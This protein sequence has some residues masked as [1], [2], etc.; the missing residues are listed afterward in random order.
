MH[1]SRVIAANLSQKE[2]ELQK[3]HTLVETAAL[4]QVCV[5]AC[6]F[7]CVFMC[8]SLLIVFGNR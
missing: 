8:V 6:V 4:L 3:T 5:C 7:V 1:N 2:N